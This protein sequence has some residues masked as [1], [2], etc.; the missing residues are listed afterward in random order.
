VF[1]L[2]LVNPSLTQ[3]LFPF[4]HSLYLSLPL[5]PLGG[6]VVISGTGSACRLINADGSRHRSGGW[7]HLIGDEGSAY[8]LAAK[9]R[10][11]VCVCRF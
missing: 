8:D 9:A 11:C 10:L 7:G 1:L 2:R 5:F 6:I 4:S 3:S